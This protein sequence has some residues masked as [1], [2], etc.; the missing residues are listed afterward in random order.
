MKS[1]L[2]S[3][4]TLSNPIFLS[5]FD[6]GFA[7]H[8]MRTAL[9]FVIDLANV[10]PQNPDGNQLDSAK[11]DD[12]RDGGKLTTDIVTWIGKILVKFK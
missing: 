11:E 4:S 8:K 2:L 7:H 6:I 10:F 12:S 1:I 5:F 3:F 9:D